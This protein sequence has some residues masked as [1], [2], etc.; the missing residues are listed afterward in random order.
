[1][2]RKRRGPVLLNVCADSLPSCVVPV[3][4]LIGDGTISCNVAKFPR[5]S[6]RVQVLKSELLFP[7]H[8]SGSPRKSASINAS[9]CAALSSN[10]TGEFSQR[11]TRPPPSP[12]IAWTCSTLTGGHAGIGGLLG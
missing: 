4:A 6:S 8:K 2:T 1:M 3:A 5:H 11:S 10:L 12:V 9:V 7:Q